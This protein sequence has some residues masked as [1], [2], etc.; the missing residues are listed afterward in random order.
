V[1]DELASAIQ[2]GRCHEKYF[3]FEVIYLMRRSRTDSG[4]PGRVGFDRRDDRHDDGQGLPR[5]AQRDAQ[6]QAEAERDDG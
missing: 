3:L 1:L 2:V 4:T 5:P 6:K